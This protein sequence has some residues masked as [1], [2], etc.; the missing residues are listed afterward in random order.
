MRVGLLVLI[1]LFFNPVGVFATWEAKV[2]DV[3]DEDK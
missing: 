1:S 3:Y 2:V